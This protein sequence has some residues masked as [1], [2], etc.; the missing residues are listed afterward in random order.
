MTLTENADSGLAQS[1]HS[2]RI[3]ELQK[4]LQ[5]REAIYKRLLEMKAP[6]KALSEQEKLINEVKEQIKRYK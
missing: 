3:N 5:F 4:L 1:K 2:D 6:N